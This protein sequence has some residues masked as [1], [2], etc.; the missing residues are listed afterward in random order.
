MNFINLTCTLKMKILQHSKKKKKIVDK[1]W[2]F[3]QMFF[4][5][6]N[7]KVR[8]GLYVFEVNFVFYFLANQVKI[9]FT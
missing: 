4:F 7:H 1:N 9:R 5:F 6:V 2:R 3:T 8:M